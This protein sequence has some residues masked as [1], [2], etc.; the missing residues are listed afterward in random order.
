MS[1]APYRSYKDSAAYR[2]SNRQRADEARPV[3]PLTERDI[4]SLTTTAG[5]AA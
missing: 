2:R 3:W 5:A 4:P 1:A